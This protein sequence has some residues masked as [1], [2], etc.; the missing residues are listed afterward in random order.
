MA[1]I[2]QISRELTE[3]LSAVTAGQPLEEAIA[4]EDGD[5]EVEDPLSML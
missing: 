4:E 1:K 2:S 3:K 5:M